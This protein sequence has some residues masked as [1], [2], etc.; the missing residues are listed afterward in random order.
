MLIGQFY[1]YKGYSGTIEYDTEDK[2][3]YG[4]LLGIRDLVNY[5]ANSIDELYENFRYAVDDYIE[6]KKEVGKQ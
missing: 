2:I 6:F 1:D 5:H 3:H 4:K